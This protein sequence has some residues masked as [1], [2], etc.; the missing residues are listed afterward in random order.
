[1]TLLSMNTGLFSNMD[2]GNNFLSDNNNDEPETAG[3]MTTLFEMDNLDSGLDTFV[4]SNSSKNASETAGSLAC[5]TG[6][7]T[8]GSVAFAGADAGSSSAA[9]SDCGFVA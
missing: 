5:A 2:F 7:E 8:A 1:M 4:A 6:V 3:S 9:G